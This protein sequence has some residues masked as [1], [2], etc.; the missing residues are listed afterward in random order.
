MHKRQIIIYSMIII[1]TFFCCILIASGQ[2]TDA[3][4]S[5]ENTQSS[6]EETPKEE[7]SPEIKDTP[8]TSKGFF[9]RIKE[10]I[11]SFIPDDPQ[12]KNKDA[13]G[14]STNADDKI[15]NF[16]I[17]AGVPLKFKSLKL[18]VNGKY[19]QAYH[20]N[21]LLSEMKKTSESESQ[22]PK[23]MFLSES[24]AFGLESHLTKKLFG[25]LTFGTQF[26]YQ[27]GIKPEID[28]HV[29]TDLFAQFPL[30]SS[31]D[32]LKFKGAAGI[33]VAGQELG[34]NSAMFNSGW[35][36]HIDTNIKGF[37]F[38]GLDIS[39][40]NMMVEAL[41]RWKLGEFRVIGSPEMVIKF[42]PFG[43]KFALVIHGEIE[44]YYKKTGFTFEPI[45]DIDPLKIRWTQLIRV[46]F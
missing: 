6:S 25:F 18:A 27:N 10:K 46:P 1:V 17:F 9:A 11:E 4:D 36:L 14:V 8:V 31:G 40:I 42:K 44:Y 37:K 13:F 20:K 32:W 22:K 33:W 45:V 15:R 39:Y 24:Y 43:D 2:S 38:C 23:W 5:T 16:S 30:A 7:D 29:H 12:S 28:P 3:E 21:G 41:P 35:H 26:D 34:T 19:S